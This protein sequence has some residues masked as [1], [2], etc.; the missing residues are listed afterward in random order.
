MDRYGTAQELRTRMAEL[1]DLPADLVAGLAHVELLGDRQFLL[2]GH[3]GILSYG[4]TQIDVSLAGG[5]AL[6]VRGE[7]LELRSMTGRD[8]RIRGRID[9]VELVR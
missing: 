1:F 4:N 5:T 7:G 3:E 9:A 8:L 6:R 2:E